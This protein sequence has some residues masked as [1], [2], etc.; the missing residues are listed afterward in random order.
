MSA[1]A[2]APL[3]KDGNGVQRMAYPSIVA[4]GPNSVFLHWDK[5]NRVIRDG[6]APCLLYGYGSYETS[7]D[8]YFSG[9]VNETS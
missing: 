9:K 8:P 2:G 5:N 1:A 4:S 6:S 7:M 3:R